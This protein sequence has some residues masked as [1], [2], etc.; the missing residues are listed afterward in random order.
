[1]KVI[2]LVDG[3]HYPEVTRWGLH[4]ARSA[5]YEVM[6]AWVVGGTE[7]L[8]GPAELLDLGGIPVVASGPEGNLM[9]DLN[10]EIRKVRPEAILD[11]SDEPILVYERRMEL[12]SVALS[13]GIPYIGP[14]FRF[15]PPIFEPSLP[16]AAFGVIGTGKRVGKTA[17]AGHTARLAASGGHH[18][19]V[20]AMGRGGP[21]EPVVTS[22]A[23]VTLEALLGR[24]A[25]GEHA[26]SDYLED[27][28]T[29]N[30]ATIGARRAGGGLAGRPFATN[31]AEAARLAASSG[32]DLVILEEAG[33][34]SPPCRG[35][36]ACWWRLLPLLPNTWAAIWGPSAYCFRT[37]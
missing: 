20:V 25:R 14:D 24:V 29:A 17:V 5:G 26:A 28:L 7:K 27:A 32:A 37:F 11:L 2:A 34:R 1:M 19:V 8:K 36:P 9:H 13:M 15:D 16:V 18:P 4:E 6:L 3:E 23:D 22:P 30:V 31:V 21:P 33:P 35:T 10:R 12:V